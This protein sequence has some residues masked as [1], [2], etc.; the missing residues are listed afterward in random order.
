MGKTEEEV[1][2]F[3]EPQMEDM[4]NLVGRLNRDLMRLCLEPVQAYSGGW[5]TAFTTLTNA[6]MFK[7]ADGSHTT[8]ATEAA[9]LVARGMWAQFYIGSF[10][11]EQ[12]EMNN[13]LQKV[14]P[15][16]ASQ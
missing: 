10:Y 1:R 12:L 2:S 13:Y 5:Y 7:K 4:P 15:K 6:L 16:Q 11:G 8:K 14:V 3:F 9:H